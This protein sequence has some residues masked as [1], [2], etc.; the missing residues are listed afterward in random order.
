[1][2]AQVSTQI[3]LAHSPCK[4]VYARRMTTSLHISSRR[5]RS[6]LG[7]VHVHFTMADVVWEACLSTSPR[8]TRQ[9]TISKDSF[10]NLLWPRTLP[11]ATHAENPASRSKKHVL[12]A[13]VR[14]CINSMNY[15]IPSLFACLSSISSN[16]VMSAMH[17]VMSNQFRWFWCDASFCIS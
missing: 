16:Q 14:V 15:Q 12:R 7:V 13:S 5:C 17:F 3:I 8:R 9:S 10:P 1:M 4:F 2:I 11:R 6:A